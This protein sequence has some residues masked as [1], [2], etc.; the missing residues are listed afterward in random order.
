MTSRR[1]TGAVA[2]W[3]AA[4]LG[5]GAASYAGYVSMAWFRY[6][7]ATAPTGRQTDAL[8]ERFMP[9]YDIA[10]RH[11]IYVAAPAAVTL[12]T[13]SDLDLQRSVVGRAI[14]KGRA[15]LLGSRAE[16]TRRPRGLL[17]LTRAVGWGVL[18]ETPGREV[19]LGA[20]TQP[21]EANVVFRALPADEFA[22]FNEPGYVK[23]A[24]TL[25][26]DPLTDRE[27]IFRTETRAIATDAMARA[28]FRRH[29]S[30]LSP[31]IILIRGAMLGTL[32]SEAERR[33]R[34]TTT[35]SADSLVSGAG[36]L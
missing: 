8:L 32:R 21:W 33:A 34:S 31:G 29:W 7:H 6:G 3:G 10:E 5:L 12:K 20:V 18:A 25:R 4:V 19:V 2:K 1:G 9:A 17:A 11:R 28:K 30:W 35:T 13:A 16:G 26:A 23:I 24:W 15:L 22:A 27:S 14:F 36:A